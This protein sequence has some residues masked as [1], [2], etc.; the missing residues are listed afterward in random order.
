MKNEKVDLPGIQCPQCLRSNDIFKISEIASNPTWSVRSRFGPIIEL[1]QEGPAP[2][3][4]PTLKDF[5]KETEDLD[6]EPSRTRLFFEFAPYIPEFIRIALGGIV[7]IFKMVFAFLFIFLT[8]YIFF[9]VGKKIGACFQYLFALKDYRRDMKEFK[10]KRR[11]YQAHQKKWDRRVW[12][13][14]YYCYKDDC[15]FIP[16]MEQTTKARDIHEFFK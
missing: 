8:G 9:K 10:I 2:P 1:L 7:L 16:G 6:E 12:S 4:K 15:V 5:E 13:R 14:M 3:K 11:D